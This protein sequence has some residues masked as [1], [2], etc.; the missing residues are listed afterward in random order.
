MMNKILVDGE[1]W[2]LSDENGEV[3]LEVEGHA[4]INLQCRHNLK[5]NIALRDNAELSFFSQDLKSCNLDITMSLENHSKVAFYHAF[6]NNRENNL[7]IMAYINGN[8]NEI[9]FHIKGVCRTK[10]MISVDGIVKQKSANNYLK[11]DIKILTLGGLAYVRPMLHIKA[12][13]VNALHNTTI[14]NIRDDELFYLMAKGISKEKATALIAHS[15]T[16]FKI[17]NNE[18]NN[19]E[20]L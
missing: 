10:N 20:I 5:L 11:E 4:Q 14:S 3:L 17:S 18:K 15:Y 16:Y 8:D 13:E 9:D 1:I 12:L 19:E 2:D 7:N 6:D